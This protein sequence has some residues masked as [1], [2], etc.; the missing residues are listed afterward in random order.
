M[1]VVTVINFQCNIFV[2]YIGHTSHISWQQTETPICHSRRLRGQLLCHALRC[3][4]IHWRAKRYG[5]S[6]RR[7]Y[8]H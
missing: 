4:C 5:T 8:G 3:L 7:I 2:R 6:C 1:T